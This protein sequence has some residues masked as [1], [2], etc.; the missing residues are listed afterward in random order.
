M[1]IVS[2][3]DTVYAFMNG[4]PALYLNWYNGDTFTWQP[5]SLLVDNVGT[6]GR[7]YSMS[8]DAN[9]NKLFLI[10]PN[11]S[12]SPTGLVYRKFNT[13][14]QALDGPAAVFV[15]FQPGETF[16]GL[17]SAWN[18]SGGGVVGVAYVVLIGFNYTVKFTWILT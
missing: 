2:V 12:V 3:G 15:T 9:T 8:Y 13:V 4:G 18:K 5:T 7:P 1:Q 16:V 11:S 6:P 14:T 10:Y 17:V